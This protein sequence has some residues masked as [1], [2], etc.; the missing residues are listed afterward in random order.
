M[1]KIAKAKS[2]KVFDIINYTILTIILILVLYPLYLI[3]ISSFSEPTAV[4]AG[5]V[6]F[7]IKGFTLKGYEILL[8]NTSVWR[9]YRNTILYVILSVE[10]G[11]ASCRERV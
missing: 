10:I 9:G 11:R 7:W 2:D 6:I 1:A 5:K 3:L 4:N 8:D